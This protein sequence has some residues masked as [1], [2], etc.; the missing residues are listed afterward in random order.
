M[1]EQGIFI[2][3]DSMPSRRSPLTELDLQ[4]LIIDHLIHENDYVQRSARTDYDPVLAM[5]SELLLDFLDR[6]QPEVMGRLHT[7]YDALQDQQR[8]R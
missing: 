2:E 3:Y 4:N 8:D 7:I 6:T 5:D 1:G